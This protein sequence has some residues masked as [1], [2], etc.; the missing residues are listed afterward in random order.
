MKH[1]TDEDGS[2]VTWRGRLTFL[3]LTLMR[4]FLFRFNDADAAYSLGKFFR[5]YDI[6]HL[7]R[8]GQV[9]IREWFLNRI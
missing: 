1:L 3:Q 6:E 5:F 9:E 2:R 7:V 4:Y 8:N